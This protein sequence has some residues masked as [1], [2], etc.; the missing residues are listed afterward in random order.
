VRN[1]SNSKICDEE[2]FFCTSAEILSVNQGN[3]GQYKEF[4]SGVNNTFPFHSWASIRV[5]QC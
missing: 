3:R 1:C 2:R 4:I 5:V